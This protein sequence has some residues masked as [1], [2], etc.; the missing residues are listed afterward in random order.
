LKYDKE[1]YRIRG[2]IFEDYRQMG[3]G[4]IEAV[5]QE[6]M[7]RELTQAGI[8]FVAQPK[9]RL[10]YKDEI[11][12]QTYKPD[13]IFYE[14]IIVEIKAVNELENEH[15]AQIY[16]YLKASN[17]KLAFLVNFGYYPKVQIERI[18]L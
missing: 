18:I 3:C 10:T 17:L 1:S 7:E 14:K 6:C 16:N 13:L 12:S 15:R 4:F 5:Y 9:L 2:A 8:P 11:L